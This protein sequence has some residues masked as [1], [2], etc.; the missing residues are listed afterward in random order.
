MSFIPN[1]LTLLRAAAAPILIVLLEDK[2]FNLAL[3]VFILAGVSDGL[4]G[5][6]AKRYHFETRLGAILDPVADKV[7]L[8]SGFVMLTILDLIPLWLLVT[9]VFR[10]VLIV[11]GYLVL[12]TLNGN[13]QMQP[14]AVSKL[15][16]VMQISLLA[17]ILAQQ[18]QWIAIPML[19]TLLVAAVFVT[20]VIS[21]AHYVW[22]WAFGKHSDVAAKQEI[23]ATEKPV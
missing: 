23:Q 12:V 20:T 9:V 6:I 18:A 3:L 4:D 11:G 1:L 8:V 7:L 22:V 19:T 16:T 21:G 10:D 15:N 14:S 2:A 5:Y 13:V 17:I